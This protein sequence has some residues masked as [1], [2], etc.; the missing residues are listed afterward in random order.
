MTSVACRCGKVTLGLESPRPRFHMEC[1]C[2]DCRQKVE[3]A[4]ACS[5]STS[6]RLA[7]P[8]DLLYFKNSITSVVGEEYLKLFRLRSDGRSPF[9][10][11]VCC[12]SVLAVDN[13]GYCGSVIMV[14]P[15]G[16][17]VQTEP[18]LPGVRIFMKDWIELP[19]PPAFTGTSLFFDERDD[20]ES[21][22][23]FSNLF[24]T[25]A[26]PCLP[27]SQTLQQLWQR[28]GEPLNLGLKEGQHDLEHIEALVVGS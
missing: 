5:G 27:E 1:G 12:H 23:V 9:C 6:T 16:C 13:V 2:H 3:W 11:A 8:P 26:E 20:P 4:A 21:A 7:A 24:D 15:Q 10:V 25:S 14:L 22:A 17:N 18:T 19:G 28:L